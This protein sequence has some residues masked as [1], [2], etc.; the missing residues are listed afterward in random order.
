MSENKKTQDLNATDNMTRPEKKDHRHKHHSD[1]D[2]DS[3][4]SSSS[5]SSEE[6]V[7]IERRVKHHHHRSP[8]RSPHK[9]R[10]RSN[11]R[12][13]HEEGAFYSNKCDD[14][15]DKTIK[16]KHFNI[17]I[18]KGDRGEIGPAGP[19]GHRGETG[20]QGPRGFTGDQG[21]RGFPGP[22]GEPG[23]VG[24]EGPMG[25]V[26]PQ[27]EAGPVGPEGPVG[28][29]GPEG[30][31]GPQGEVGPV[32]PEGPIGLT[33]PEGPQGVPGP[34]GS[35]ILDYAFYTGFQAQTVAE[36]APILLGNVVIQTPGLQYSSNGNITMVNAGLYKV[37]FRIQG[38]NNNA[39]AF[40]LNGNVIADT[41][42][43][44]TNGGRLN[45][46]MAILSVAAGSVLT[47]RNVNTAVMNLPLITIGAQQAL[48]VALTIERFI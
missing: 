35:A 17:H 34:A 12:E 1:S 15:N 42:Y 43:A 23:P 10:S 47:F 32:G 7:I 11:S 46:G 45:T 28:P 25:P 26:G 6:S 8:H 3:S 4:S 39:V 21:K 30:P 13:H 16:M 37:T 41:I 9:S 5:S 36:N 14:L 40:A 44:T 27:G 29:I 18:L 38:D 48:N 20:K 22:Q 19:I 31:I 33:G 24:P 2:S